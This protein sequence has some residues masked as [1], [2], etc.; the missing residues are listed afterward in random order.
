MADKSSMN[1]TA[2]N[3]ADTSAGASDNRVY[4]RVADVPGS[5]DWQDGVEY[6]VTMR[7]RQTAPGEGTFTLM[8]GSPVEGAAPAAGGETAEPGPQTTTNDIANPA[9]RRMMERL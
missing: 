6:D 3:L 9:M 7:I 8:E 1:G 5:E 4:W 2:A